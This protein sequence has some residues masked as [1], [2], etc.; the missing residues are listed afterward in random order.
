MKA[1]SSEESVINTVRTIQKAMRRQYWKLMAMGVI[2]PGDTANEAFMQFDYEML[3]VVELL[4]QV[5]Y[6]TVQPPL[7]EI[8][9]EEPGGP[10]SGGGSSD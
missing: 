4:V 3:K 1:P 8:K 10:S 2:I 9:E 7:F 5:Y 6:S